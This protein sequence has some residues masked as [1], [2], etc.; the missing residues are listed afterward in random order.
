M[1]QAQRQQRIE[2][3]AREIWEAEGR[4]D[5][6]AERHWAMAVRLVD[7]EVLATQSL[8]QDGQDGPPPPE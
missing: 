2:Q 1:D 5:G 6:H 4:P 7:A 8:L 3:L